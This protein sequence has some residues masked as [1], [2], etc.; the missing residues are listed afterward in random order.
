MVEMVALERVV[1]VYVL[2][3]G[4]VRGGRFMYGG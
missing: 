2:C 4:Y 1:R 3:E